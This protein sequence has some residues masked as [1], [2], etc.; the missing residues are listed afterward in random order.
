MQNDQ[1]LD[2]ST[3]HPTTSQTPITFT[4]NA[5]DY[6]GIWIV[7]LLLSIVTL[8][9]YSAW[10]KVRRKKYF[11]QNTLIDGVGFDYHAKPIAILKGR[12]IAFGL[13]M[14]YNL[15]A[16]M[17]PVLGVVLFILLLLAVPWLVLRGLTFNARNSSHRG[18][19]FDF[20]SRYVD[21]AK[22][23]VLYPILVAMS[24]GLAF[25]WWSRHLNNTLVN[26]HR[27]GLTP[28]KC[29]IKLGAIYRIY[30]KLLI[31][32][33]LAI[34]IFPLLL[35]LGLVGF[36][37]YF[38]L[39]PV[40]LAIGLLFFAEI[41]VRTSNLVWNNTQLDH[42][43]FVSTQRV[44]D[45]F[46]LYFTNSLALMF[47]F[48]LATP[49]AQIRLARYRLAHLHL[50]GETQWDNFVGEKKEQVRATGEEIADMFDVDMSFG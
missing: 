34:I 9:I 40:F 22:V 8:G 42:V 43:K 39:Y 24:A 20:K 33:L 28:F 10:A 31:L 6:F 7:N 50:A 21:M 26:S 46:W 25:P 23:F 38:L 49:W 3:L 44:R 13:L 19:R 11:Y 18:L 45:V 12:A 48:G 47:S 5:S 16:Q 41:K 2:S 4:G 15:L 36:V 17:S 37:F 14:A 29:E 27:F 30:S 32:V 1:T 35:S